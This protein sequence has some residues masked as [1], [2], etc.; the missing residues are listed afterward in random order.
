MDTGQVLRSDDRNQR[1]ARKRAGRAPALPSA[2][3]ALGSFLCV[4]A[5]LLT[6][7]A[8][9]RANRPP[10]TSYLVAAR[11][12][13]PNAALGPQDVTSVVMALPEAL[14]RQAFTSADQLTR[15]HLIG[16]VSA[17]ELIQSGNVGE[18]SAN[19]Q[20]LSFSIDSANAA[21]GRI[22]VGDHIDVL[23]TASVN[24]RPTT[25]RIVVSALVIHADHADPNAPVLI[26]ISV[27]PDF[28]QL[29]FITAKANSRLEV[30][31]GQFVGSDSVGDPNLEPPGSSAATGAQPKT[32][33]NGNTVTTLV[34]ATSP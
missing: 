28:D 16:P 23:S 31:R 17:G 27:G 15:G 9:T 33:D 8:Y 7:L 24:G 20:E 21:G 32:A 6:L 10:T 12:L 18:G 29:A 22:R 3:A 34:K 19:T 26:T 4:L 14:R 11:D 1:T 2:R 13:G 5:A 25:T 30:V